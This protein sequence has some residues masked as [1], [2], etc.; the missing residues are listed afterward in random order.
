M[1]ERHTRQEKQNNIYLFTRWTALL[2]DLA[3]SEHAF[4]VVCRLY[5]QYSVEWMKSTEV[6]NPQRSYL[7]DFGHNPKDES[8]Y[9]SIEIVLPLKNW[10][11]FM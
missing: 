6:L 9:N 8:V 4:P 1:R 5:I 10:Y 2:V 11:M 7:Q 3:S